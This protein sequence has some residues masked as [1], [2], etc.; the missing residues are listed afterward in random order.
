MQN[1]IVNISFLLSFTELSIILDDL[2]NLLNVFRS[3]LMYM[4]NL[5]AHPLCFRAIQTRDTQCFS[6]FHHR[7]QVNAL[8]NLKADP[9]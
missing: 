1:D 9:F 4:S 5:N 8:L 2:F 3:F 6:Q 7:F